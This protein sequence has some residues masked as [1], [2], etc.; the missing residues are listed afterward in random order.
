MNE[1]DTT[2]IK[3]T[4]TYRQLSLNLTN[5]TLH[6]VCLANAYKR[7]F[8]CRITDFKSQVLVFAGTCCQT[9][10]WKSNKSPTTETGNTGT[11]SAVNQ[12][13]LVGLNSTSLG[14]FER[15]RVP[16]PICAKLIFNLKDKNES[17]NNFYLLKKSFYY[18]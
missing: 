15:A 9:T 16:I 10:R 11:T 17:G 12:R 1:F 5:N 8:F 2:D 14:L 4:K 13:D 7:R 6:F 3:E 18:S